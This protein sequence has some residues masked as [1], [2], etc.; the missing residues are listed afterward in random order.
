MEVNSTNSFLSST[1]ASIA[2]EML[3]SGMKKVLE[4]LK[5]SEFLPSTRREDEQAQKATK[6]A[7]KAAANFRNKLRLNS[8]HWMVHW[9]V[10]TY[11]AEDYP[12]NC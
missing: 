4:L 7:S 8:L 6:K 9:M 5:S 12:H 11:K 2:C 10:L 1:S 3:R